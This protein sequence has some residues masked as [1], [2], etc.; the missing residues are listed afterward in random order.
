MLY[1]IGERICAEEFRSRGK[2][3]THFSHHN[4]DFGPYFAAVKIYCQEARG[5]R[6]QQTADKRAA[7]DGKRITPFKSENRPFKALM[8]ASIFDS[9]LFHGIENTFSPCLHRQLI[10]E[11]ERA[12]YRSLPPDDWKR[13][14]EFKGLTLKSAKDRKVIE[15]A[16]VDK[17]SLNRALV[18]NYKRG[19]LEELLVAQM[20]K[21]YVP[22][23]QVS[24]VYAAI[25]YYLCIHSFVCIHNYYQVMGLSETKKPKP[26]EQR[27]YDK[28]V[29]NERLHGIRTDDPITTN[30]LIDL[31]IEMKLISAAEF[32]ACINEFEKRKLILLFA[33]F[34]GNRIEYCNVKR[35]NIPIITR[36]EMLMPCGLHNNIR[37]PSNLLTN[38]RKEVSTRADFTAVQRKALGE[39]LEVEI[40]KSIGSGNSANFKYT[41]D[42]T[43]VQVVSLSCVKLGDVMDNW[44]SLVAIVFAGLNEPDQI[45]KTDKWT[46]LGERFVDCMLLL[47]Y[48]YDMTPLEVIRFQLCMDIFCGI[49]REL[50]GVNAETNYIQNM[51]AGVFRYFA[52]AYGSIY[53]YNNT[54]MEACAGREQDFFQ[55]ATQHDVDG[56]RGHK[57]IEA[58]MNHHMI[59]RSLLMNK[60]APGTLDKAIKVGKCTLNISRNRKENARKLA[61]K[62][63]QTNGINLVANRK[64][65]IATK[66]A[67]GKIKCKTLILQPGDL[68]PTKEKRLQSENEKLQIR[69]VKKLKS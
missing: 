39:K 66:N 29:A 58:F 46:D 34:L 68:M 14:A 43:R 51:S 33:K 59:E 11:D 13:T 32:L 48:K 45:D 36:I 12:M 21:Y 53:A 42:Q 52:S 69:L 38:L 64:I 10:G 62:S 23:P 7:S 35:D 1:H 3:F 25:A 61:Q 17:F 44:A 49:F 22:M 20:F 2:I 31:A 4:Y 63:M 26:G 16:L 19:A 56:H 57:L 18:E 24:W 60:L 28:L 27:D 9:D 67:M 40:N 15:D 5:N 6:A 50:L 37:V 55:K 47:N 30:R 65:K 54:A 41:I 8:K